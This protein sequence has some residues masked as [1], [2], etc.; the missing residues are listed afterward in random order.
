MRTAIIAGA[1]APPVLDFG[2]QVLDPV[3]LIGGVLVARFRSLPHAAIRTILSG[4]K[5]NYR[6]LR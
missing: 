1:D 5:Q 6:L 2:K 3:T 4:A